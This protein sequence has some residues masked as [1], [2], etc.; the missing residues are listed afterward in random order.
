MEANK[1]STRLSG[2]LVRLYSPWSQSARN[3]LLAAPPAR[4]ITALAKLEQ[5]SFGAS[6][7][8]SERDVGLS[9]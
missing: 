8:F 9:K 4:R 2:G 1:T 6:T 7:D 5:I 3:S